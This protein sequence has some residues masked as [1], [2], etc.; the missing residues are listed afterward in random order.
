M[1]KKY[2]NQNQ[3]YKRYITA[4]L[5]VLIGVVFLRGL[6]TDKGRGGQGG[7][8][9][10]SK[11]EIE[12]RAP[13]SPETEVRVL[14]LS[15]G[16]K[17]DVHAE[18]ILKAGGG[19]RIDTEKGSERWE[20]EG[21][22]R[23]LPDDERFKGGKLR[24]SPLDPN[25]EIQVES[26]DRAYGKPSYKGILELR[27][28]EE[29]IALINELDLEDYLCKVVP[30]EMPLSYEEEAL[31]AQ[32]VCARSY[33]CRQAADY[34]YP[35]YEAHMND[36]TDFQV[37]NN[38]PAGEAANQ[39]VL[40]T[41]GEVVRYRGEIASTYYYS[42][43]C[44]KTTNMEAWGTAPSE[45]NQYLKSIEVKGKEG[46][47][48]KNL[49][50]YRWK[51]QVDK[52]T[53]SHLIKGNTGKDIGVLSEIE[54]TKRGAGGVAVQMTARGD[55]GEIIVDT[56]GKI[57]AALGGKGY[58]IKKNDGSVADSAKLLPSAF[59]SVEKKGESFLI[60]GGGFGHGIGMSQN[61]AN[62]MAKQGKNYKEILKF[63]FRGTSVG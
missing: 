51:A 49:P 63:F 5:F 38:S 3:K 39:A 26:I 54:I 37:Y 24:I 32:A 52:N 48:E 58:K 8:S 23:I 27:T 20:K 16:Y 22:L 7:A 17:S 6:L 34:A 33:A 44:G 29:G 46:D 2:Q 9:T 56:E 35:D 43:S 36:S 31:K 50:W 30:S 4:I 62:E 42:T 47:Y 21:S 25:T 18:V 10:Q 15:S 53:L 59:F 11:L 12:G 60:Q 45:K 57:R 61:G 28:T 1:R 41:R 55:K 13:L 40:K 19:L 14:L